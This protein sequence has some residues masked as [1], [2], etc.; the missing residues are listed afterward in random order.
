MSSSKDVKQQ[1]VIKNPEYSTEEIVSSIRNIEAAA[2]SLF[3]SPL[4]MKTILL[5]VSHASG[6]AQRDVERV[7]TTLD[8]LK[9]IYLKAE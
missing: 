7:L 3:L 8:N 4:K 9:S 5:L 6:V 1:P 2:K